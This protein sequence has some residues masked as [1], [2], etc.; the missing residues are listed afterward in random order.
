M[1]EAIR[2]ENARVH[3]LKG[4]NLS[5][6]RDRVVVFTGVSGSGKSSLV[7]DTLHTEAQRQLIETFSSFARRRLPKLSRPEV[8]AIHNLSTSIVIDQHR[9]GRT[10]RSTVGTATEVYTYLR[11]LYSRCGDTPGLAS[12]HFGFNHPEGMCPACMGLGKR[13]QVDT[14]RMLDKAKSLRDGAIT[15]P[16]Y[17]VGGW[18]WRELVAIDMFDADKPLREFTP[19]ELEKLLFAEGLPIVKKHGAGTYA[20]TWVGIARRLERLYV[21]RAEDELSESRRDAYHQYLSYGECTACGGLRLAPARL[22]VRL[23]GKGIG[24]AVQME[25]TDLDGWLGTI[26]SPVAAPLVQK[27]RSILSNLI[28]IGVGY[29]SLNRA[30]ATLSGGESQRIK[31][32]RQLDCDLIGLMYVMDEPSIGLHA[33][34]IDQLIAMLEHLRDQGNSVL[35]VEHDPAIIASG[36]YIV[37]IG[38]GPGRQGGEVCFAG[39]RAA[40]LQSGCRTATLMRQGHI[41]LGAPRRNW[42]QSWPIRGARANNLRNVDVDIP[43]RVLVCVTGVAGSGKSSLVHEVFVPLVPSA[44]VVDQ[45]LIGCNSRS[46]PATFLGVFDDVRR[47]FARATGKPASWF[48]YN[49]EGA[50]PA[51]KGQGTIAVEMHFLDDVRILCSACNGQRYTDEVLALRC[52]GHNIHEVLAMTAQEAAA[53]FTQPRVKAALRLL[54]EVGLDYLTLGQPLTTLSGG[55]CQRL[56]LAAELG[57]AGQTYIL[58]EPTTGLHLADISR[59]MGILNR[60]VQDGNSVIVIEHNLS[61]IAQADWVID[62]G[63]EGGSRGGRV[64]AVG[65]PEQIAQC[66][67]SH[68]GRYLKAMIPRSGVG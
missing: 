42:S 1:R 12:F 3:N 23:A 47:V 61:V 62:L 58:D 65:T 16:D 14:G 39:E 54:C 57:K 21:N 25:L 30:V 15:H 41:P 68:T 52:Q 40:F 10:L 43:Q 31:M 46:N 67:E 28:G 44:V 60:L 27:M 38:P 45:N 53:A 33:R 32:A 48:S 49:S 4:I 35:V 19:A 20:K 29:L 18:N 9:L 17:R 63:P 37:E 50:C 6:P 26:T 66:P 51:C 8:D 34:D 55:E 64:L 2:I 7:F 24:E 59:L 36:D 13:I 56:K 22:A 11:L 5:I